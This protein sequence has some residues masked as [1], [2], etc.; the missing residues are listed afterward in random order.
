[1]GLATTFKK[2]PKE[3]LPCSILGKVSSNFNVCSLLWRRGGY[4]PLGL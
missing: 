2:L 3:L 4:W 1:M